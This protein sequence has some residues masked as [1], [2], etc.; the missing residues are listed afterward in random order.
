MA[1]NSQNFS[2]D[3][4]LTAGQRRLYELIDSSL[5]EFGSLEPSKKA[6]VALTKELKI[7]KEQLKE[8]VNKARANH[9]QINSVAR[10]HKLIKNAKASEKDPDLTM[11]R[12]LQPAAKSA[13]KDD[14]W[15]GQQLGY[16]PKFLEEANRK[17][18]KESKVAMILVILLLLASTGGFGRNSA[19]QSGG[20]HSGSG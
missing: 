4:A 11:F 9:P 10:V 8:I 13:G 3:A 16:M 6:I 20:C 17:R 2:S 18:G 14:I 1:G 15:L 7:G 19:L 5:L 12:R